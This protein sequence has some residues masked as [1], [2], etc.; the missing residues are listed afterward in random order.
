MRDGDNPNHAP[1]ARLRAQLPEEQQRLQALK[2]R[3][4]RITE[5]WATANKAARA[6]YAEMEVS[7]F[8]LFSLTLSI[9]C[10]HWFEIWMPLPRFYSF[11]KRSRSDPAGR[12]HGAA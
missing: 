1:R 10:T 3:L 9:T 2:D 4:K 12:D 11:K 6:K 8:S 7:P 5:Q